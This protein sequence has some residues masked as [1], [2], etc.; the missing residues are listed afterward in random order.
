ME[1]DFTARRAR[2]IR[3]DDYWPWIGLVGNRHRRLAVAV[4]LVA[5]PAFTDTKAKSSLH[6]KSQR[7]AVRHLAGKQKDLGSIRF[8]SPFSSLQHLWFM[9]TVL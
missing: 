1:D 3:P 8:G 9:D 2:A 4:V 7:L 5:F 6:I